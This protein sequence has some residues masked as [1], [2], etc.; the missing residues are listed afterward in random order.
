MKAMLIWLI[1]VIFHFQCALM[2]PKA[3]YLVGGVKEID[4]N[5]TEVEELL[6]SHLTRLDD[7]LEVIEK[8]KV[9]MQVVSGLLYTVDGSFKNGSDEIF[10][11]TVTIWTR[12]WLNDDSQKVKIKADCGAKIYREKD[13]NEW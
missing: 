11:C 3:T 7:T 8:Q 1:L 12:A 10:D 5:D 13:D 6:N 9:T 4:L 2:Q